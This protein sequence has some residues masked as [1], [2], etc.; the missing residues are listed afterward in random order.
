M[1]VIPEAEWK[2]RIA[3]MDAAKA[4]PA[5]YVRAH[6]D[7]FTRSQNGLNYCWGWSFSACIDVLNLMMGGEYIETAPESLGGCVGYRNVGNDMTSTLVWAMENGIALRKF[8]P[9][10]SL[11]T[12][13]WQSGWQADAATRKP[14]ECFDLGQTDVWAETVSALLQG[15]AIYMGY[16][17]WS[18]ALAMV[19]VV[20]D[21]RGELCAE[22]LNSHADGLI[23]VK[24][25]RK[26]PT[27]DYGCFAVR[28]K[29]WEVAA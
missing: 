3:A 15:Y 14:V 11:N 25:N 29:T 13:N 16:S 26:V 8:V 24:G 7:G 2:E 4:W 12:R 28:T 27:I 17:W 18:H 23:V 19:R 5:D 6:L 22:L 9:K 10:Y 21:S 1:R 20:Y